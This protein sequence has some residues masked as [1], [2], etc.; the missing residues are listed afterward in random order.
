MA[1]FLAGAAGW[2][3]TPLLGGEATLADLTYGDF[4]PKNFTGTREAFLSKTP[5][6][7]RAF[8]ALEEISKAAA[9]RIARVEAMK[10][11]MA[12]RRVIAEAIDGRI[13]LREA[14]LKLQEK[15]ASGDFSK[16]TLNRLRTVIHQNVA[17]AQAAGRVEALTHPDVVKEFNLWQFMT[18]GDG[19][20]GKY[21]VTPGCAALHGRVFLYK[22]ML[23]RRIVPPLHY[24]C[25]SFIIALRAEDAERMGI[26]V[27]S[28]ADVEV[29]KEPGFGGVRGIRAIGDAAEGLLKGL[30]EDLRDK[31]AALERG[32]REGSP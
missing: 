20:P 18:V 23:E 9:F 13:T 24:G 12:A 5:L 19:T 2:A 32:Q 26:R 31:L 8:D 30:D 21:G 14:V 16:Q 3:A 29:H 4:D 15:F 25:R 6:P 27:Q 10:D 11:V 17:T 1:I 28:L 22:E 7:S